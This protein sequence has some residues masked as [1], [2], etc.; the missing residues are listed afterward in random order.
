ML[1]DDAMLVK[2]QINLYG[3]QLAAQNSFL[4]GAAFF[5]IF[6]SALNSSRTKPV[7]FRRSWIYHFGFTFQIMKK[8]K[9][10]FKNDNVFT[11]A[12]DAE[13]L[14]KAHAVDAF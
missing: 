1:W 13:E 9:Y 12:S 5:N 11:K 10:F 14:A 2:S 4:Y 3:I 6:A 8:K 7:H